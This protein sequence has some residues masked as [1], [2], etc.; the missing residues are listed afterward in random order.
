MRV[1]TRRSELDRA[2]RQPPA[3]FRVSSAELAKLKR[4]LERLK[5]DRPAALEDLQT[6][7]A[8]GD[9]SENFGYQVAKN[10]LRRLNDQ[11]LNLE[12]KIAR[13]II[14]EEIVMTVESPFG[15]QTLTIVSSAESNPARN[16]ISRHSPLGAALIK[17][18][19]GDETIVSAPSGPK[20][21]RRLS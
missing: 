5:V 19:P 4:R 21:Y 12:A 18:S 2:L 20:T 16:R 17:L 10:R 15:E 13:A 6:T 3:D 8:M 11:I 14:E 9:L 7:L 1:P